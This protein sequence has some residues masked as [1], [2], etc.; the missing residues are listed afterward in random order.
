[1][2]TISNTY[3]PAEMITGAHGTI[4][5]AIAELQSGD[6]QAAGRASE[7]LIGAALLLDG[8][9]GLLPAARQGESDR[10]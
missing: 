10:K 4:L 6:T 7:A 2:G 3:K 9:L 5:C 1:M 8:A